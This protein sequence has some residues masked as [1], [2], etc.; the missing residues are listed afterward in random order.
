MPAAMPGIA[1]HSALTLCNGS[2]MIGNRPHPEK[3]VMDITKILI[4]VMM[5]IL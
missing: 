2:E 5:V 4:F 1:G 3:I